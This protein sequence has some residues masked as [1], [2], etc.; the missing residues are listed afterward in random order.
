MS[1]RRPKAR[2]RERKR[3]A[4]YQLYRRRARPLGAFWDAWVWTQDE[5]HPQRDL[6]EPAWRRRLWRKR[7][8]AKL[9]ALSTAPARLTAVFLGGLL[10]RNAL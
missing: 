8:P 4:L 9:V 2:R 1:A 7:A 10:K 3:D 5:G 6:R